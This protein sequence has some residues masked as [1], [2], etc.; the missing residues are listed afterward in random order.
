MQ[1]A[2]VRARAGRRRGAD[3]ASAVVALVLVGLAVAVGWWLNRA[4]VPLYAG[5]APLFATWGPH[6][7]PGTPPALLVAA[8]TIGYGPQLAA[9]LRWPALLLAGYATAVAWIV[10]LALIDGWRVGLATR[11]TLDAEY[12]AEVPGVTDVPAMV[13][14]FTDR[15]LDFQP[16]SWVTHV[17]GHPPGAL[18]V[19][20]WL[21]RLGLSGG[22][23][24][25]LCC[26][27]VGAVT[28]V[29]VPVTVRALGDER[30]A[31]AVLPFVVL[32]PGA[33]WL[34]ASADAIFAGVTATGIA[35][36]AIAAA[37]P[38]PLGRRWGG[39]GTG[40]LVAT[41]GGVLLGFGVFLSYG[42]VLIV[43]L[44]LAVVAGDPAKLA[45]APGRDR[46]QRR[47][48]PLSPPPG[49]GGTTATSWWSSATTRASPGSGRTRTGSGPTW[50][51]WCWLPG[52]RAPP[53]CAAR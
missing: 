2:P 26:V 29:A 51:A 19:F 53:R 49:S 42:L 23:W 35:L 44:V 15:I 8:A 11:L 37:R 9:R 41:A 39:S 16:D 1:Q 21:D 27:A 50:P 25:G 38:R 10:S 12:L 34:G 5:S 36:L 14:G 6:L 3:A 43:P 40:A 28:A 52:R 48:S 20:V 22:G 18:L 4:G 24:A 45:V 31:R 32:F 13:R 17:S 46:G 47:W 30:A 33:V 7:G